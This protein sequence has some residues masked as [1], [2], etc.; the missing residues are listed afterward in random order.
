LAYLERKLMTLSTF[1]ENGAKSA[2]LYME[3]GAGSDKI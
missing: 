3:N 1:L 2:L